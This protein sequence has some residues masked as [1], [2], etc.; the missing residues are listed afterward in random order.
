MREKVSVLTGLTEDELDTLVS[1]AI[2]RAEIL[3]ELKSPRAT[4]AWSEIMAYEERLAEIT[5]PEDISGGVARVGAVTAALAAGRRSEASRLAS[6]YLA[7]GQLPAE[8]RAA[9]QRAF[10]EDQE[11]LARRFPALS[12]TGRLAELAEWRAL[13][14]KELRVFPRAA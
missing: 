6:R 1:V 9:I 2:R 13:A 7:E 12:R 4:D 5:R 14:A 11:R 10:E 3:E 8:R